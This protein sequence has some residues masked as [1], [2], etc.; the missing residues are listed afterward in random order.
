MYIYICICNIYICIYV[1]YYIYDNILISQFALYILI[2]L[3]LSQISPCFSWQKNDYIFHGHSQPSPEKVAPV[4]CQVRHT[5]TELEEHEAGFTVVYGV[6]L[7]DITI[8]TPIK[9][10]DPENSRFLEESSLST[11]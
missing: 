11:Q 7:W 6:F 2:L 8:I 5:R 4:L 10:F 1:I 9:R 3:Q